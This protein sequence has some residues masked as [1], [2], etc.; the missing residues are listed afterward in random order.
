MGEAGFEPATPGFGGQYSIQL[1][2]PPIYLAK[3]HFDQLL[4]FFGG[5]LVD[6]TFYIPGRQAYGKKSGRD[7]IVNQTGLAH[8][9]AA[10][11]LPQ[12]STAGSP[13]LGIGTDELAL[14]LYDAQPL[15][16]MELAAALPL[17][18]QT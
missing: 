18:G 12:I 4:D 7:I 17:P 9:P 16:E 5:V 6:K 11:T 13:A 8:L 2:Y 14:L 1:S 10:S 3:Q 15:A